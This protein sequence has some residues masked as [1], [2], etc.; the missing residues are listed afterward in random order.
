[1][2]CF[3]INVGDFGF[4]CSCRNCFAA[5]ALATRYAAQRSRRGGRR[6]PAGLMTCIDGGSGGCGVRAALTARS[7]HQRVARLS[8]PLR[9][10]HTAPS[11]AARPSHGRWRPSHLLASSMLLSRRTLQRAARTGARQL[12]QIAEGTVN[13]RPRRLNEKVWFREL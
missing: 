6:T 12:L 13:S 7:N 10:Q 5:A 1:M 8:P 4:S 11:S 2:D 9:R 3:K